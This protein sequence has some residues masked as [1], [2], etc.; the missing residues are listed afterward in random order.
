LKLIHKANQMVKILS[1]SALLILFI[2][3]N[4]DKTSGQQQIK[5]SNKNDSSIIVDPPLTLKFTSGIRSILEDSKGNFWFGSHNEGVARYDG[6]KITYYSITDGLSHNQV[7]T[8]KEDAS[9]RIWFEC[10]EGTSFYSGFLVSSYSERNYSERNNWSTT[11]NDIWF[12]GDEMTGFNELEGTPGAYRH[13]GSEMIYQIF[14]V[15][16][17]K[18]EAFSYSISAPIIKGKNNKIWFATYGAVIG[19]NGEDFTIINDQTLNLDD[20]TGHFHVRSIFEDSNE[21]LWIGNNGIGV[22]KY[23]GDTLVN[24]SKLYGL[25]P[26]SSK[27]NGNSSPPGTLEHV[28]SIGEDKNGHMWFGDRDTG[29]WRFDG[30]AFKNF[31]LADGLSSNH[32]WA[33]Y[34][35]KKDELWYAMADGSVCKFNGRSF[36][37]IL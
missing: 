5:D 31:T 26:E 2:S 27:H 37:E 4:Q 19:Y 14:P 33:I 36:Y 25:V 17:K 28:F 12:K 22:L 11:Q 8:I 24:M 30:K 18:N 7:R 9:G 35:D 10:G 20:A 32:I 3:C 21:N 34:K 23:D 16:M 1:Q 13:N 15:E 29:A 6:K